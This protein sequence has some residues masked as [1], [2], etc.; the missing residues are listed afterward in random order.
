MST[1]SLSRHVRKAP[2]RLPAH[3]QVPRCT[4]VEARCHGNGGLSVACGGRHRQPSTPALS[5]FQRCKDSPG[6]RT[7][8]ARQ[9]AT[10][11]SSAID[12]GGPCS[13]ASP[14]RLP[15]LRRL[16]QIFGPAANA[17][18]RA[19]RSCGDEETSSSPSSVSSSAAS[20]FS[21][22][23]LFR[24]RTRL[25]GLGYSSSAFPVVASALCSLPR[26]FP[27]PRARVS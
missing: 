4:A 13:P 20:P 23:H 25:F 2:T 8:S 17:R 19:R 11:K 26:S 22:R 1:A 18:K 6:R 12:A 10:P 27:A 16:R 7:D 21:P 15:P 14:C 3:A 9:P 24:F 5:P